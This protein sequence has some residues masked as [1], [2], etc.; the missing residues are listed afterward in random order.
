MSFHYIPTMMRS[1]TIPGYV[2]QRGY[3][4]GVSAD[5]GFLILY[6]GNSNLG[7]YII[8]QQLWSYQLKIDNNIF[9]PIYND[10]NGYIYWQYSS[11]YFYCSKSYGWVLSN[12]FPGYEP[13]EVYNS[14]T[15]EFEGDS[16]HSGSVPSIGDGKYSYLQPRGTNRNNGGSNK[17]VYF[18]FP[19]W[20]ST[21][22][23][24]CGEYEP[25]CGKTGTKSVGLPRWRDNQGSYYVRSFNRIASHYTYGPIRYES[26]KWIIGTVNSPGGWWEGKEPDKKSSVTFTFCKPEDSEITGSNLTLTFYDYVQ[27][28]ESAP[29]YMGEVA[30]WR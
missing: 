28:N 13:K 21:N 14:E 6:H 12:V 19:R 15:H 30:I 18:W 1:P 16:F 24:L 10:V 2:L 20:Q 26:G 17:T 25:K 9:T 7:N 4:R 27:G 29:A 22:G 5:E 8:T 23:V 3:W 11:T